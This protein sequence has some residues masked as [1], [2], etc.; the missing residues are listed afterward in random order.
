MKK[1]ICN[2]CKTYNYEFVNVEWEQ[3]KSHLEQANLLHFSLVQ[4]SKVKPQESVCNPFDLR[5]YTDT[6]KYDQL[7][8]K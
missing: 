4:S 6:I 1:L 2:E 5:N 3:I 8:Y 7:H